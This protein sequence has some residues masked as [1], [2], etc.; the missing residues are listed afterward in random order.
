MPIDK[1]KRPNHYKAAFHQALRNCWQL[2]KANP[3][4]DTG[5][6]TCFESGQHT[7]VTRE[8]RRFRAFVKSLR[9]YP[10]HPLAR[11][12][13]THRPRTRCQETEFGI[14]QL[15]IQLQPAGGTAEEQ[16]IDKINQALAG[17]S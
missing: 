5:W 9:M 17:I 12:L 13:L 10:L 16:D 1:P 14:W 7:D 3:Q 15:Q 11:I 8:A 4:A 2:S 6:V